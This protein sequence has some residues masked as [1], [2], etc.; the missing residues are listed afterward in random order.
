MKIEE[1]LT[2]L[3]ELGQL[4]PPIGTG[5]LRKSFIDA[6]TAVSELDREVRSLRSTN[7]S[8][9]KTVDYYRKKTE[10]TSH[11]IGY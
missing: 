2:L 10:R 6:H 1:V 9:Y 4:P 7:K 5:A 11:D 3:T 8:L